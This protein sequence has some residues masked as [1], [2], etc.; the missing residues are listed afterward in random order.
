M[1][2]KNILFDL[3]G[4]L[5]DTNKL[6]LDS[7]KHT[8]KTHLN[9]DAIDDELLKYFG[10]PLILTLQRYSM[11]KASDM[12]NTYIEYNEQHHDS[13]VLP[14]E[15]IESGLKAIKEMG[16]TLAVV[17]SKR[18]DIAL[19]GLK[20]FGFDKYFTEIVALEDTDKHKPNPEPILE[21]LKRLSSTSEGAIMIG[22]SVFDIECAKNAG[23]K[24]VLVKWSMA[25]GFQKK[26]IDADYIVNS[27]DDLIKI[28]KEG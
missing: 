2:Y 19:R 3:D 23:V 24:S 21:A 8:I 20:L 1:N 6:I 5:I 25:D 11:D 14:C 15:G 13:C 28:V 4:T 9:I 12:F 17:T 22:D 7:F 16:C 10:E 26:N 27:I 18:K